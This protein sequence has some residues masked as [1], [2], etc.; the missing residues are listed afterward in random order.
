MVGGQGG[1]RRW[2]AVNLASIN[3]EKEGVGEK[4]GEK[5]GEIST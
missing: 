1:G 5:R 2:R 4:K 3:G